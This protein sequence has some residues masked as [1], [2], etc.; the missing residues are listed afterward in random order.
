MKNWKPQI[1]DLLISSIN[2]VGY[3]DYVDHKRKYC[4][5]KWNE[6]GYKDLRNCTHYYNQID[7]EKS[8]MKVYPVKQ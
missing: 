2:G 3:V 7:W 5:I 1:G 8:E 4:N 6:P